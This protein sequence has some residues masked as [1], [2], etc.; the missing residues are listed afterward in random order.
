MN[1]ILATAQQIL[2]FKVGNIS[3]GS[4]LQGLILMAIFNR[5]ISV[6]M[7]PIID[8]ILDRFKLETTVR[9]FVK[10]FIKVILNFVAICVVAESIGI[11][12]ASVLA[13][14][15]MLG[16]AISLSVQGALS[17]VANGF[18]ILVTKPFKVGDYVA[19][20]GIEGF[21]KEINMLCTKVL[22]IDNKLIIV[23]NSEAM[24]GKI[25]N[26]SSEELR[27]VDFETKAGYSNKF[28]DVYKAV[29][30]AVKDTPTALQDPAPFVRVSGYTDYTVV[31]TI[32]V[33]TKSENYWDCY[34]DLMQ[35]VGEFKDRN[36]IVGGVPSM[37]I[38]G[39]GGQEKE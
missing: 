2:D 4:I 36:G 22:S 18:M 3:V 28:E 16:L 34:F 37:N 1:Q 38:L 13:V 15:G 26:F 19:I 9:G 10:A 5:I 27:R 21:V 8:K 7:G 23:P 20:A 39:V 6:I 24:G 31:Y 30:E 11:P 33:W 25:T 14:I 32:R 12:I 35:K 29:M 17:N